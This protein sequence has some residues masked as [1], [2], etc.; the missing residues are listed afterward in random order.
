MLTSH[1]DIRPLSLPKPKKPS[2]QILA[3]AQN[4]LFDRNSKKEFSPVNEIWWAQN[5]AVSCVFGVQDTLDP[6]KIRSIGI[7]TAKF[8]PAL[9]MKYR[10]SK[11]IIVCPLP[12]SA[13]VMVD[14]QEASEKFRD[15]SQ[16][17]FFVTLVPRKSHDETRFVTRWIPIR[18][19]QASLDDET[20][21]KVDTGPD[22]PMGVCVKE[23]RGD[24]YGPSLRVWLEYY[25][26]HRFSHFFAY[27]IPPVDA[28]TYR[29][30]KQYR[31]MGV[32]EFL[33][34]YE[35]HSP[36]WDA[37]GE[38]IV[39]TGTMKKWAELSTE[40]G[41]GRVSFVKTQNHLYSE[42]LFR[43]TI[44]RPKRYFGNQEILNQDCLMKSVGF[45]RWVFP[46]L[47]S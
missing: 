35:P 47:K 33:P 7:S 27:L 23:L 46:F 44:L 28:A 26:M 41:E 6:E 36:G 12:D 13:M 21:M 45:F 2:V 1:L 15:S 40:I 5:G 34:L 25:R 38:C 10:Y 30:M 19:R 32:L 3:S 17:H 18:F 29:L 4:K 39:T 16:N 8:H 42:H 24:L 43:Y 11:V 14:S 22:A 20:G 31:D 37:C 9:F